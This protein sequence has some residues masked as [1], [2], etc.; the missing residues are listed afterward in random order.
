MG[1]GIGLGLG[2]GAGLGSGLGCGSGLGSGV[3]FTVGLGI[4]VGDGA[5]VWAGIGASVGCVV[6]GVGGVTGLATSVPVAAGVRVLRPRAVRP[7]VKEHLMFVPGAAV[8]VKRVPCFLARN[9]KIC[10]IVAGA[11]VAP[12]VAAGAISP[13]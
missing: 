1:L 12:V 5:G 13:T 9:E 8:N 6:V 4:G 3:G 2:D 11:A 10:G 7:G